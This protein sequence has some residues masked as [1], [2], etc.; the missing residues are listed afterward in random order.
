EGAY[1]KAGTYPIHI[2]ASENSKLYSGEKDINLI[3]TD[4]ELMSKIK[5]EMIGE[6]PSY[7]GEPIEPLLKLTDSRKKV[8]L[9]N[10]DYKLSYEDS[11]T[12]PGKHKIILEGMGTD[13]VGFKTYTF[14]IGGKYDLTDK[15]Y[16]KVEI[17][18]DALYMDGKVYYSEGGAVPAFKVTYK[19]EELTPAIDY[20][21][22]Y[23]DNKA[24]GTAEAVIKG[25]GKYT[26]SRV[27]S[28]DIVRRDISTLRLNISDVK[29]SNKANAYK[30][31]KYVFTDDNY[32]DQKLKL[33]R[34]YTLEY[35]EDYGSPDV[36][37]EIKVTIAGKG[38]YTGSMTASYR[39]I[40]PTKD[41]SKAKVVINKG[42]AYEYT[43]SQI[44]PSYSE[45]SLLLGKNNTLTDNDYEI[46][47]YY[48]NVNTGG[49]ALVLLRGING[50]TGSR[51]VKFK[52]DPAVIR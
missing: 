3:I 8:L 4:K 34:D 2:A 48:N 28:F 25:K 40:D 16:T 36:G 22:Q 42:K 23:L 17:D 29:Y 31:N 30:N 38:N 7:T 37:T 43:G 46:A 33:N 51:L 15:E 9:E 50:Y 26:G 49:K 45:I 6:K 18:S 52:I 27:E 5:V 12:D 35:E 32:K 44:E 19:G 14:T 1:V 13:Y 10:E 21:L 39:V 11:H 20:Q 24:L 47:G 41:I